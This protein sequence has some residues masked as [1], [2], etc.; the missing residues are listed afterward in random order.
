MGYYSTGY[1]AVAADDSVQERDGFVRLDLGAGWA[2]TESWA[3][4]ARV[5]NLLDE[6]DFG[7]T[8]KGAPVNDEGKL[9]RVFWLGTDIT[10]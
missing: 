3:V 10:F 5:E 9:G 2:I 6:R 4:R 1:E 8:V 7:Q